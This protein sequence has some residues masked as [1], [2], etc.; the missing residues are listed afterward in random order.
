MAYLITGANPIN[1]SS[2]L[3]HVLDTTASDTSI[4]NIQ[5]FT[6]RHQ[7]RTISVAHNGNISNAQEL[8]DEL[9]EKGA[10]FHSSIDS[11]IVVH[12][13]A[14]C[15]EMDLEASLKESQPTAPAMAMRMALSSARIPRAA[16]TTID[17][18]T[19]F[20]SAFVRQDPPTS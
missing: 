15:G 17:T 13:L 9:Q 1:G 8:R 19:P 11:E 3:G 7:G 4:A 16:S 10:I 20:D 12:L 2:A 6:A 14:P 18:V 5:P